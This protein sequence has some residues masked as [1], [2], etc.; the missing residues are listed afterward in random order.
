MAL[1]ALKAFF[2][3][4]VLIVAAYGAGSWIGKLLPDT[5][6]EFERAVFSLLGGLGIL[7]S[8]LFLVGQFSFARLTI[9]LVLGLAAVL[10]VRE[11]FK[12]NTEYAPANRPE[13]KSPAAAAW[14]VACALSVTAV[15]GLAE[16]TGDWNN[17]AVAYHLLGP[18]VWLRE[19]VIRPVLDN[20]H[21]AFPQIAETLFGALLRIGGT[22]APNFSGVLM[23]GLLLAVCAAAGRRLGM[24]ERDAWWVAAI[25]ATMPAVFAGSHGCFIDGLYAAFLIAAMRLA[26]DAQR[27]SE[28]AVLG[29]FCGFAMGTKYTGLLAVPI[30][31]FCA[32]AMR[33]REKTGWSNIARNAVTAIAA[34]GVI[35]APYYLRN[36]MMLG[37]PIYPPPPGYSAF[38]SPKYMTPDVIS[39]FHAYIRERGLGMGRG[40]FAFLLLPF[41]LTYHT[42]NFHGAGGIGLCPL[43]LGPIGVIAA[44]KNPAARMMLLLALLLTAA[45]FVTQQESRFLI[46]VYGMAAIFAVLGW[47]DA[48]RGGR[49]FSRAIAIILVAISVSYGAFMIGEATLPEMRTV[50]S[51]AYA[52]SRR[53][54]EIPYFSSFDYLNREPSVQR[55]LV[56]DRSVPP[57]YLDKPYIKPIGQWGERTLPGAP[58]EAGALE[59]ARALQVTHVLDVISASSPFQVK[60][61]AP[62]LRLVFEGPGQR[63]YLV[64]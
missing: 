54:Q 38:C 10:G 5:F 63:V 28:W 21:T 17:D 35:A 45:W 25:V 9:G 34:G 60:V 37:C 23:L 1:L 55:V 61:G 42:A 52:A 3:L 30:L 12:S 24:S 11:V 32:I 18:K 53:T 27:W 58:D 36:W 47:R 22:R 13:G 20:S 56:L 19:G 44:R 6:R 7:S 59:E 16:I 64:E 39:N 41:N 62:G 29:L 2:A 50:F 8:I 26:F 4:S 40:I 33:A 51:P 14:I 48:V 46:P 15:A 43:G 49:F 31:I 57:Y